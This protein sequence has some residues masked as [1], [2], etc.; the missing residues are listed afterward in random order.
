[1]IK[2]DNGGSIIITSSTA[3]DRGA[4]NISN[5][6]SA[7]HGVIGLMKSLANELGEYWI[8]VNS[9]A[10]TNVDTPLLMH[11]EVYRLVRPDLANPVKE[12]MVEVWAS[13]HP[14]PKPWQQPADVSN[15]VLFLAS[16]EARNVTGT[17]LEIDLGF[18]TRM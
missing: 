1:M 6:V 9:V 2:A 5:Y 10:P 3:R 11:D 8:R 7:K 15:A 12:D 4:P 14:L 18:T 16:D 17:V 13:L